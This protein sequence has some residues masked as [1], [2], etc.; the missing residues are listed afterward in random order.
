MGSSPRIRN[1]WGA[2]IFAL[3]SR[4]YNRIR[5]LGK[6]SHL[7][8]IRSAQ[9]LFSRIRSFDGDGIDGRTIAYL[10]KV[11]PTVF[12]E[13]VLTA[14]QSGGRLVRRNLRYTGDG[15]EDGRFFEPGIGWVLVQCKRYGAH[16]SAEHV[17]D[18]SRL[19]HRTGCSAGLFVHTGRSG[20]ETKMLT[21]D[22][23]TRIVMVSGAKLVSLLRHG[24]LP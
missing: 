5:L 14:L 7:R 20:L 21:S 4:F 16:I 3:A 2:A 19:V 10:K 22:V 1:P 11:D 15:G 8:K 24:V 12:E 6:H 9:I 18:F 13:L 17:R 23:N